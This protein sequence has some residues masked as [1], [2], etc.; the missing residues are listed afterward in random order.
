[1]TFQPTHSWAFLAAPPLVAP[2]PSL[3][4]VTFSAIF[5]PRTITMRCSMALF[6]CEICALEPE[7][8]TR[9]CPPASSLA[10]DV[11]CEC[12]NADLMCWKNRWMVCLLNSCCEAGDATT[13]ASLPVFWRDTVNV[14][15]RGLEYWSIIDLHYRS[16]AWPWKTYEV[17]KIPALRALQHQS[18]HTCCWM[19]LDQLAV[20]DCDPRPDLW[21]YPQSIWHDRVPACQDYDTHWIAIFF[22]RNSIRIGGVDWTLSSLSAWHS[23]L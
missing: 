15:S 23:M 1:M 21:F 19:E 12:R 7:S 10:Q 4:I 6:P 22:Q 3:G 8:T 16:I 17:M 13:Y 20:V 18:S 2:S 5:I 9:R 11:S 14:W